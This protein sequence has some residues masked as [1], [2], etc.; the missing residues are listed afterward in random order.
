[1]LALLDTDACIELIRGNPQ[2]LD[3]FPEE[4]G[5]ISTITRFEILSGLRQNRSRKVEMRARAFLEAADQRAFEEK[6]AERAALIRIH[7]EKRGWVIGAYDLLL[8]GHALAMDL[9]M[10][11]GNQREFA[12]VPGLQVLNWRA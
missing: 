12:R 2:P 8:A 11:S 3:A 7:L 5:V 10:I 9:P 4:I 1:M 6:A